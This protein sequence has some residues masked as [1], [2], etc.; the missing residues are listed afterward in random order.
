MHSK[1]IRR[2]LLAG[3]SVLTLGAAFFIASGC[4]PKSAASP[5]SPASSTSPKPRPAPFTAKLTEL[6]D[7]Q[8]IYSVR[9]PKL[10]L[11][12]L[13]KLMTA[14]PEAGMLRMVLP[15]L[16]PYGYPEFSELDAASN[17]GFALLKL[18][19][20]EMEAGKPTLVA[21]AKLKEGGKIWTLLTKGGIQLQKHDAWT[22]IAKDASAFA[23]IQDF[24]AIS[25]YLDRPQTAELV[26]WG[27]ANPEL[28]AKAKELLLPKLLAKIADRPPAEQKAVLAYADILWGCITQL[29]SIGG[30]LDLNDQGLTLACSGQFLPETAL[31]TLL[32]YP[33]GPTPAIAKSV[34][35]DALLSAIMRQNIPAQLE[36]VGPLL[37]TFIAVDYPLIAEPLKLAKA[38]YTT[39]AAQSD[40]GA[41][42]TFNMSLPMV[43][44]QQP[45][46]DLLGVQSG[47]F[48]PE[49]VA[50]FYKNGVA[51]S[52]K[53]TNTMLTLS[54]AMTKT[55]APKITQTVQE[56]ALTIDGHD[57]GSLTSTTQTEV[58]GKTQT[59]TT[60]Q[61]FGVV[62]KN[63]IYSTNEA[64]L[65]AKLPALVS[66][67][68][69]VNPVAFTFASHDIMAMAIHGSRIVDM[70]AANL[71]LNLDDADVKA[72]LASLKD[73][74]TAGGPVK[75]TMAASQAEA[76]M[77]ISI[78]YPFIAQSV[79]LA[80]F[81]NANKK[82]PAAPVAP[83]A[84]AAPAP[85]ATP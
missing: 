76:T 67:Q 7:V 65:R 48:T 74:Y 43:P 79:Q 70:V 49:Q 71:P 1:S 36:F 33:P 5:T 62:N 30:S 28:L 64:G 17:I 22:W 81:A 46:I 56:K 37:D 80:Q 10:I 32:R 83:V 82:Q 29:H 59:M 58:A 47:N 20:E 8:M 15:Q 75:M 40:G 51:L 18:S 2:P 72:R 77:T 38:S 53:F 27:R 3:V 41:A 13:D 44:G 66:G 23:K 50:A 19:P 73:A 63:L 16:T 4:K 68:P 14:V 35:S 21:F 6:N 69:V 55:A 31:G 61:Y 84:P 12:D 34:P 45:V 78:P 54:S 85:S 60:T 42:M 57:F 52:D 11:A 24:A 39:F 26:A 9:H 25:A